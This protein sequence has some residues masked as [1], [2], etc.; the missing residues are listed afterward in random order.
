MEMGVE[1]GKSSAGG[2]AKGH[3]MNTKNLQL[4][5]WS[6]LSSLAKTL[7]LMSPEVADHCM[8]VAYLSLRLG[9]ELGLSR[10]ELRDLCIAG[11]LHDIGAFSLN[12]R[13]DLLAFEEKRATQHALAGHLLLKDVP[14]FSRAAKMV[15]FHHLPWRKGAGAKE[16]GV[17]VPRGSHIVHLADRVAVRI[18]RGPAIL[19]QV[20]GICKSVTKRKGD[21]FVPRHVEAFLRIAAKDYVWLDIASDTME[22]SLE[23][24]LGHQTIGLDPDMLLSLSRMICRIIDFKSE[25]TAT[26]SSGVA[27]TGEALARLAGFSPRKRRMFEIA[28]YLHDLGKLAI[29]SEILEKPG[30]LTKKEWHVMRTHV[31]YTHQILSPIKTFE[32]IA[33]WGALHQE[34]L[35]GSGYPFHYTADDLPLGARLMAVADVFTALTEDR[36]YRKGMGKV[37]VLRELR[38]MVSH[39]DL[40]GS[41]VNLLIGQYDE[42]NRLRA[43]A[44]SEAVGEYEK[45]R[46]ALS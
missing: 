36:P 15:R 20:D 17:P 26:H 22:T 44:Q 42:I 21:R 43:S 13:L 37:A 12:E 41:L 34:R 18:S 9:E 35:N 32:E 23:R 28:A 4:N 16:N 5:L 8:R 40:D 39:G 1:K 38:N 2:H 19:G 30:R 14:L 7:D 10:A 33:S 3:R 46:A 25:F 31:Y 11:A 6:L 27:A 29:P 24:S 45:F